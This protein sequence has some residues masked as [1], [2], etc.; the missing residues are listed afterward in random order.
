MSPLSTNPN[1]RL[2]RKTLDMIH[3]QGANAKKNQNVYDPFSASSTN[4]AISDSITFLIRKPGKANM[5]SSLT[6]LAQLKVSCLYGAV[7][8]PCA[9]TV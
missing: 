6:S 7:W 4:F 3:K 5:G 2:P 1:K 8:H 9:V